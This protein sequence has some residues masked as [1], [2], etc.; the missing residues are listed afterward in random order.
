MKNKMITL[1]I[2]TGLAM[3]AAACAQ[4]TPDGGH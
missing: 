4:H 1:I 3:L 2:L